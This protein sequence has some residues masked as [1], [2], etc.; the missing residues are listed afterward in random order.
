MNQENKR[1]L[2]IRELETMA[3]KE[4][5]EKNF[6]KV[7][8]YK[9]VIDQIKNIE[10]I[11]NMDDVESVQGI[12]TKIKAKLEEIFKTGKLKSAEIARETKNIKVYDEF[13]KI[14]GIGI[15]KAKELVEKYKLTTIDELYDQIKITPGILN[16]TQTIGLKYYTDI[17]LKIPRKEMDS[18]V[19]KINKILKESNIDKDLTLQVVGSYR[20]GAEESGDIDVLATVNRNINSA[21]RTKIFKKIIEVMKESK[22]I[23]V[24]LS[25]GQKKYMGICQLNKN[26]PSRRIDLLMTSCEEYPYALLYF[27]GDFQINIALRK[28]A[29]E[30]GFTLNEY[31]LKGRNRNKPDLNSE[32]EIF[33]CLGFKYLKPKDRN[34]KNLK[35]L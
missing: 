2:I 12:G 34:I 17:Q 7:R 13:L 15:I 4:T 29:I 6:F 32:K 22:Y 9:K 20:R 1:D 8:A 5:I 10:T 30:L 33:N 19:K 28:Q 16:E 26:R 18:H 27:T 23:I 3:K 35:S 25:N 24:D 21:K 14:H 31:G 11:K